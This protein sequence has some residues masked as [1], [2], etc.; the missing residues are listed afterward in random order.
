ML[1]SYI[2]LAV[3]LPSSNTCI[4]KIDILNC[5]D[6][7]FWYIESCNY[8]LPLDLVT[9]LLEFVFWSCT[10][11]CWMVSFLEWVAYI[12]L[13][14]MFV[15]EWRRRSL[16]S[17]YGRRTRRGWSRRRWSRRRICWWMTLINSSCVLY[18][19]YVSLRTF[20]LSLGWL[21]R[22]KLGFV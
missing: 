22:E 16:S 6:R 21:S 7:V 8:N 14:I 3:P 1:C 20:V 17:R 11:C 18:I 12:N 15:V 10:S 2:L 5:V 13:C 19:L 9:Y 4:I